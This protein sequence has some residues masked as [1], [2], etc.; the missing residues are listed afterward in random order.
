MGTWQLLLSGVLKKKTVSVVEY[1]EY[2]GMCW[3]ELIFYFYLSIMPPN[4]H[5]L[6]CTLQ[7]KYVWKL[8]LTPRWC[9]DHVIQILWESQSTCWRDISH[10][11]YRLQFEMPYQNEK[12]NPKVLIAQCTGTTLK[13]TTERHIQKIQVCRNMVT[14]A[15]VSVSL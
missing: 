12:E 15:F 8:A 2:L 11:L 6:Y 14:F 5:V 3:H 1:P 7:W 10:L 9:S 13:T 4:L